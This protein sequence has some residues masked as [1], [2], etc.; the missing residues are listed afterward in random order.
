MTTETKHRFKRHPMGWMYRHC[1][2]AKE[3][4]T[5]RSVKRMG[6]VQWEQWRIHLPSLAPVS[7]PGFQGEPEESFGHFYSR[8]D[9]ALA[10]DRIL[11]GL[12][13][14]FT[15]CFYRRFHVSEQEWEDVG[16]DGEQRRYPYWD[17]RPIN[18]DVPQ[19]NPNN[20]VGQL[21][22]GSPV[23]VALEAIDRHL[24]RVAE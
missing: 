11:D 8:K 17:C 21:P 2:L 7:T 22:G 15:G 14:E 19:I 24:E 18:S 1:L 10:L 16:P 20:Y 5:G 12:G 9:A 13:D 23:W 4:V 3:T 6:E